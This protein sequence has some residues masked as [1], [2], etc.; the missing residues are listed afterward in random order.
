MKEYIE[1]REKH[2]RTAKEWTKKYAIPDA[3]FNFANAEMMI[4]NKEATRKQS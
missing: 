4:K 1:N 2:D 3:K